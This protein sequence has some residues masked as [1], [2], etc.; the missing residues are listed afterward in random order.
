MMTEP[1]PGPIARP[2]RAAMVAAGLV[3]V[4]V[5]G[6]VDYV[7]GFELDFFAFYLIPIAFAVWFVG[8]GFGVFISALCVVVSLAGD[9][10]AGAS[11]SSPLVFVWNAIIALTFYSTVVWVFTKLRNLQ[12]RLEQRVAERTA[13]LT[14]EMR[15]RQRLEEEILRVSEREQRRIGH[16]LHDS[17]CQQLTGT[18]F[19]AQA[20]SD[21]LTASNPAEAAAAGKVVSLIE[22]GIELTRQLARGLHPVE[23][24]GHGLADALSELASNCTV[25][26]QKS[27]VFDCP[28]PIVVRDPE[29]AIHLFRIVQ[30]AVN[31]A[32]KHSRATRIEIRAAENAGAIAL[33]V[34]DNGAGLPDGASRKGGMGLN[35]MAYRARLVGA[36]FR[37]ER[38]APG[39]TRIVVTLPVGAKPAP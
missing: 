2:P 38:P 28:N 36:D 24:K 17:L 23:L 25:H 12:R 10:R 6:L 13:A 7:T 19:A 35:I 3:L 29:A 22:D 33:S 21:R 37:I 5:V 18:A 30:E 20:L 9:L 39:G 8:T 15:E 31:N 1:P 26:L 27:C 4:A 11:F 34:T 32:V 16:D 14:R